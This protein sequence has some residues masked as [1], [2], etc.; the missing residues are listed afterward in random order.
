MENQQQQITGTQNRQSNGQQESESTISLR[1]I[2]FIVINNW[3]WFAISLFICLVIAGVV[4]KT[5]PKEFE[6]RSTI[7]IRDDDEGRTTRRNVDAILSNAGDDFGSRSLDDVIFVIRS[8]P[9]MKNVVEQLGLNKTCDRTGLFTKV[10]YYHDRP[11]EMEVSLRNTDVKEVNVNVSVTPLDMNRYQ[12]NVVSASGGITKK[13]GTAKYT[14]K[15]DINNFITISIDKTQY[16]TNR[17][18]NVTYN[19]AECPVL[20]K[21][22][23]MVSRLSVSRVNKN[24]SVLAIVYSDD[25]EQRAREVTD[26]M[27][28]V[29]NADAINDKKLIAEKTEQFVSDRIALISGELTDVD[30]QVEQ[31]K[32]SSG[33]TDFSSASGLVLQTATRYTDEVVDLEAE[34]SNIRS[35]K[36]YMT[37]PANKEELLPGNVGISNAGVQSQINQ[38][39]NQLLQYKKL[40]NTAGPKNPGVRNLLQQMESNRSAILAAIDN[41]IN[42]VNIRLQSA[43]SQEMRT[44]GQISAM[45]TQTKAVNEVTRHQKLKEDFYLYL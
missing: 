1:D 20:T 21:A 14:E 2:V 5:K 27:A 19:L 39:N 35:I 33:V 40:L 15:V 22:Y 36:S 13:K 30:S 38:Y 4:F 10:S 44:R 34:L 29:Y 25:N 32:R 28:V 16:F 45:P 8:S 9:M 26:I 6:Y 43:R 11:L 3:Y 37:D 24:A 41:L 23:Q 31:L 18:I 17:N 42:T 12:Y 7:M